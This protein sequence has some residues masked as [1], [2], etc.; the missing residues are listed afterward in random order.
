VRALAG[1][2]LNGWRSS[3]AAAVRAAAKAWS[4]SGYTNGSTRWQGVGDILVGVD[5][6]RRGF[7]RAREV[8]CWGH[9]G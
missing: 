4:D 1:S 3:G 5:G 8:A 6:Q 7:A 9:D 2:R